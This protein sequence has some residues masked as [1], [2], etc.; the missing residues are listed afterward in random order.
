M[1]S[2]LSPPVTTRTRVGLVIAA[3]L[4]VA[5]VISAF[6]PTPEG[7]VGPPLPIVLL[8]GLL[9]VA[10]L[11]AVVVAWRTGRRGALRIVAGTRVLSA[12]T[13]LPGFFVDIPAWLKLLTAVFVV[14]TVVCVVL[15]L[16][17]A[18]RTTSIAD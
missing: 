16:A 2:T 6:F 11:A 15:V 8:G 5:D 14:L 18:R 9:G 1:S 12:I 10:T 3:L 4:G 17:P 7:V 13:A